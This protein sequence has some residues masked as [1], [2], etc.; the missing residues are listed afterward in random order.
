MIY[1]SWP[2]SFVNDLFYKIFSQL[3]YFLLINGYIL[4]DSN[5]L[6]I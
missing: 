5:N 2:F 3:I 6:F 1:L 4:S